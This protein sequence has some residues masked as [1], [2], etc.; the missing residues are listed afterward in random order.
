MAYV[1]LAKGL[2]AARGRNRVVSD[3]YPRRPWR[4]GIAGFGAARSRGLGVSFPQVMV[5]VPQPGGVVTE[6]PTAETS[7]AN[8]AAQNINDPS[9]FTAAFN[10]PEYASPAAFSANM[11]AFAKTL[12]MN[13]WAPY[14]C[15]GFDPVTMGQKYANIVFDALR[16]NILPSTGKS[17]YDTWVSKPPALPSSYTP[18][19]AQTPYN[20]ASV[21]GSSAL[22][23]PPASNA[24]PV[25]PGVSMVPPPLG[26]LTYT[27][28]GTFVSGDGSGVSMVPPPL[29]G[30]TYTAP[31]GSSISLTDSA[32]NP[33]WPLI[34]GGGALLLGGLY[35]LGG[36]K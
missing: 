23:P 2:G 18:P 8:A 36:S 19:A 16:A 22:P 27:P 28:G 32:G 34:L 25:S 21:P 9:Q 24:Q 17:V 7:L 15:V 10:T 12:C 4:R 3:L 14:T 1:N 29:G 13:S 31:G 33:N 11:I 30:M 26:G 6:M 20:P 5:P 35:F